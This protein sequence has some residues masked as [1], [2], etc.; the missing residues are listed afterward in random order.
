MAESAIR[1]ENFQIWK[2]L[3]MIKIGRLSIDPISFSVRYTSNRENEERQSNLPILFDGVGV[4]ELEVSIKEEDFSRIN[5]SVQRIYWDDK[6][7]GWFYLVAATQSWD[8]DR[9]RL[10]LTFAQTSPL[11]NASDRDIPTYKW[12]HDLLALKAGY[13]E[14][15]G[16]YLVVGRPLEKIAPSWKR[17]ILI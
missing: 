6:F 13:A 1:L 7:L 14:T 10:R 17:E 5:E 9:A 4:K 15:D 3:T 2:L 11:D 12:R 8:G 16:A